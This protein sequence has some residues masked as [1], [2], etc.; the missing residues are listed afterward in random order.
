MAVRQRLTLEEFLQLPEEKPAL[1]FEDG[2]A[3]QKVSPRIRHSRMQGWL[4][5]T[6]NQF[7]V[8]RR[9]AAAF[10]ELR[11]TYDGVSRVPDVAVFR[12]ERIPL[13]DDGEVGGEVFISPAIAIEILSPEQTTAQQV[14]RCEWFV[15]HGASLALSVNPENRSVTS[16]R[17]GQPPRRLVGADAVELDPVLSG[18]SLTVGELFAALRFR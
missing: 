7:A 5:E 4:V 18:F 13:D 12:W 14:R 2:T 6:I 11:V 9:L 8:P 15:A 10:P 1:E 17:A 3:T 16:V